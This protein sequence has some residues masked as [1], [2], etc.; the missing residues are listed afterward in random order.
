MAQPADLMVRVD[1][2]LFS[3]VFIVEELL[4]EHI[5]LALSIEQISDVSVVVSHEALVHLLY[6]R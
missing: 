1:D 2:Q 3:E 6:L 5:S 4:A